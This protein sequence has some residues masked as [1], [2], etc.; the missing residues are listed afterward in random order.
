M[1][2]IGNIW[3]EFDENGTPL[4][5]W[6]WSNEEGMWVFKELSSFSRLLIFLFIEY[7]VLTLIFIGIIILGIALILFLVFRK[8][9]KKKEFISPDFY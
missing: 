6:E 4:G 1:T 8:R 5:M 9:M 2:H 3:I 7:L